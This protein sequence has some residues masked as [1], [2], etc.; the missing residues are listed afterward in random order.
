MVG[1]YDAVVPGVSGRAWITSFDQLV[2]DPTD[3]FRNGFVVGRPWEP[4]V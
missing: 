1:P 4:E 2:L 3:P